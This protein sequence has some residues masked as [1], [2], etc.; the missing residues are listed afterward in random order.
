MA[1]AKVESEYKEKNNLYSNAI[2][3]YYEAIG[4][5][6][7]YMEPYLNL[8]KVYIDTK[9]YSLAEFIVKQGLKKSYRHYTWLERDISWTYEPWDLLCIASYYAGH[10]KD[11]I[12]YAAKA[13]SFESDNERLRNNLA[14]CI[15]GTEDAILLL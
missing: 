4:I 15:N 7:T 1:L 5:E 3:S 12:A 11:S 6:P 2:K 9:N 10:K 8:A 13:L 14:L